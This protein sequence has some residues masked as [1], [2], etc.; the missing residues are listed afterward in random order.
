MKVVLAIFTRIKIFLTLAGEVAGK[1]RM[2]LHDSVWDQI[3]Q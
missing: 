2:Y 1:S 3:S